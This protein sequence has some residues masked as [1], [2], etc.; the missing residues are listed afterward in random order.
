MTR[1]PF[2]FDRV[3]EVLA[4]EPPRANPHHL[5]IL[6]IAG[7][8]HDLDQELD[9]LVGDHADGVFAI[10]RPEL[11]ARQLAERLRLEVE[12]TRLV[13][14]TCCCAPASGATE[15]EDDAP[16]HCRSRPE[17]ILH[18]CLDAFAAAG[19]PPALSAEALV[20]VLGD[21]S[22]GIDGRGPYAGLTEVRLAKFLALNNV[23][24]CAMDDD[25]EVKG[26]RRGA[27][28]FALK[29]YPG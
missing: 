8:C 17:T 11:F 1:L 15:A 28:Q 25:R 24:A 13:S 29:G 26:Y 2:I 27:V 6:D 12:L 10:E 5:M 9:S 22:G 14:Q 4:V 16:L 20:D 19:D 23:Y 18:A 7:D 3:A 21:L